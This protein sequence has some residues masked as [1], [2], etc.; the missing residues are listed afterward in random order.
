MD[1]VFIERL[2]RRVKHEE[3]SLRDHAPVREVE[4][5]LKKWFDRYDVSV[6]SAPS[7][8]GE[9]LGR[10]LARMELEAEGTG[11]RGRVQT[12]NFDECEP[13]ERILSAGLHNASNSVFS[14][15]CSTAE[16]RRLGVILVV[17]TRPL[18][19]TP[20]HSRD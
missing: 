14:R 12:C 6:R 13:R 5:G 16:S 15:V 9:C 4:A 3:I 8:G 11:K 17:C 20:I 2:W 18:L 19:P 7:C 10:T 1:N